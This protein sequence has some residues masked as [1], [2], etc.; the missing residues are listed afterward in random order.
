MLATE[1]FEVTAATDPNQAP[2]KKAAPPPREPAAA[3]DKMS[4]AKLLAV[5]LELAS[6]RKTFESAMA[7]LQQNANLSR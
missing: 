1:V 7:S 3:E 6:M 4:D 5:H 2:P